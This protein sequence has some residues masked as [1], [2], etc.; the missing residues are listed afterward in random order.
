[1]RRL[2][3]ILAL[4]A[5][6][7]CGHSHQV[8]QE[9]SKPVTNPAPDGGTVPRDERASVAPRSTPRGEARKKEKDVDDAKNADDRLPPLATSPAGLLEPGA[10]KRIQE[11]LHERG[12]LPEDA[13]SGKLDDRTRKALRELQKKNSLPATGTPDDLTLQKLGLNAG[14]LGRSARSED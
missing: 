4:A 3:L 8:A 14:E 10:V 12:F 9:D 11:R 7:A 6:L 1:V 2:A 5:P 13:R